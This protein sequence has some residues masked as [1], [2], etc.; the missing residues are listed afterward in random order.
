MIAKYEWDWTK[1]FVQQQRNQAQAWYPK[2]EVFLHI[3]VFGHFDSRGG[4]SAYD[5]PNVVE[6]IQRY[7]KDTG[8]DDPSLVGDEECVPGPDLA[9]QDLQA[10]GIYRFIFIGQAPEEGEICA[11][12]REDHAGFLFG[13]LIREG[14]T[15]GDTI[16]A[17]WVDKYE[18][19]EDEDT[20]WERTKPEAPEGYRLEE[21]S[22]GEDAFGL[23][24][25]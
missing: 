9:Y 21:W 5:A 16:V 1:N 22:P 8:W 10:G 7:V 14:E 18:P 11:G 24:W 17:W 15:E 13:T 23:I 12:Y 2:S 4:S 19:A 20:Q 25:Q 3:Y 6:A